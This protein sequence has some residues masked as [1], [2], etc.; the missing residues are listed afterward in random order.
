MGHPS[1]TDPRAV[2]EQL[3]QAR[4]STQVGYPGIADPRNF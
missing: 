4:Q 2:E 1:I 3:S